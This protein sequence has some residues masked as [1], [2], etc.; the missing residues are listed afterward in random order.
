M[1]ETKPCGTYDALLDVENVKV[2]RIIVNPKQRL[3]YQLHQKRQEQWVVV[4][5]TLTVVLDN[6]IHTI[7]PGESIHIQ[8]GAHHRSWN[9]KT[10][11]IRKYG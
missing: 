6:N 9:K 11:Y 7:S 2:K 5:G 8:L 10:L 3:S 1:I 4:E